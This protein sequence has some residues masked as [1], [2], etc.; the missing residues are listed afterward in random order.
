M[1]QITIIGM[2]LIGC[3]LGMAIRSAEEKDAPLV[4]TVVT[5]YDQNRRATG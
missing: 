2:G 1:I 4:P 5:G 3:S